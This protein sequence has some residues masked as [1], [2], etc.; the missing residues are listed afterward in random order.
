MSSTSAGVCG[1]RPDCVVSKSID[2]TSLTLTPNA[3]TMPGFFTAVQALYI[4][5]LPYS[6]R[7][8]IRDAGRRKGW[9]IENLSLQKLLNMGVGVLQF[10][11]KRERMLSWPVI[12]KI[13]ISPLCNLKCTFC[14]HAAANGDPVLE[15]QRF[16]P[17]QKMT[18]EQYRSIIDQIAGRSTAVSLY[19]LGDPLV[20]PDLE[21]MCRIARKAGLNV[22][23]STN[24]SFL[25]TD[26]RVQQ[27]VNSGLT[28]LTVC[29][30]GLDQQKY[31]LTRVGGRLDWVLS[32]LR[33]VC[34]Y[35][36]EQGRIYP[37]V[38]VQYINF[39]HN[40]KDLEEAQRLFAEIGVDQVSH[41]W[42]KLSNMTEDEP[43]RYAIVGSK[44]N[45]RLPQCSW[46]HL[47]MLIKYNGDV[48]PCCQYRQG[49]QYT[50]TGDRTRLGN[51]FETSVWDIWNS[52]QYQKL[53]RLVSNP[54]V[55]E[56]ESEMKESF[57]YGCPIVFNT[58]LGEQTVYANS[59]KFEELYGLDE[60]GV[61]VR[62]RV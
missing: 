19:Y 15:E 49:S 18:L 35:R 36:R 32:N 30:D 31:Q 46:P 26:E 60:K 62:H 3:Q 47:A 50:A 57:C 41:F 39:Q 17:S 42:G 5:L 27:L 44:K 24:F 11:F 22:H 9:L 48:I 43:G 12:V 61:P 13:D 52:A 4:R 14:V 21:E 7:E 34:N 37:K 40:L 45:Q 25:L 20:H 53:R 28:H 29:V 51:V 23:I 56:S 54:E 59:R 1:N 33:R 58:N 38:E 10:A 55:V 8:T 2:L 16:R 6:I